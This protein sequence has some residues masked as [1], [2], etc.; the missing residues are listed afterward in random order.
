ML[1]ALVSHRRGPYL[2]ALNTLERQ[3]TIRIDQAAAANR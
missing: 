1:T 2:T 3:L